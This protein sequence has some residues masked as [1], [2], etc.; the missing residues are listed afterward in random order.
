MT[1]T[2]G[3]AVKAWP[4]LLSIA[5]L[6]LSQ[7]ACRFDSSALTRKPD[8]A[9]HP[10][11]GAAAVTAS[12]TGVGDAVQDASLD[13]GSST[14]VP[15]AIGTT[16]PDPDADADTSLP[17]DPAPPPM[18]GGLQCEGV[19]C[20][21]A[22]DP[23]K[24]CCTRPVDV[25]ARTARAAG[26]C[27]LDL[28]A[29]QSS[30]YQD[31]CWQ[32]DQLGILDP[33]CPSTPG[34][35]DGGTS[36]PGC[37]G[38]DG[39]CGSVN[40]SQKLSCRHPLGSAKRACGEQPAG[41]VCDPTGNFAMRVS[42]DA[43]W[44]GRSGGLAALTDD[45]RGK[46]VV[47]LLVTIE[48]VDPMTQQLAV[49]GRVCGVTF[50]PFYS[51]T[52]CESYQPVFPD[53]I[54]EAAD[55]PKLPLTGRYAC[56]NGSCTV[57]VDPYTYLIGFEMQ[58][59]EAPWPPSTE[60]PMLT[61]PSGRGAACFPDHD[62]DGRAGVQ[63]LLPTNGKVKSNGASC[64]QGYQVRGAPLSASVAAIFN[65]VRR[66]DR[67][68]LGARMKIGASVRLD[69]DCKVARG[70]ALAEYVN[71]RAYGC[72]VEPG[73]AD[74]P[75]PVG[76]GKN[77]LCQTTEATFLDANLPLY[78]MLIAGAKPKP[79]LRLLDTSASQGPQASVVRLAASGASVSCSDVRNAAY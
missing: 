32:R 71:S 53:T 24:P 21:F 8:A 31:A 48:S 44:G 27:G 23:A 29:L 49:Q 59:R 69:P 20:P 60:T 35:P 2:K 37:C 78:D 17:H 66:T 43:A 75:N 79:A 64:T 67:L 55:V 61:C 28:S 65:G 34:D 73:T 12:D 51:T 42:A 47:Y 9:A 25:D 74:F 18:T 70:S 38:D 68:L 62:D 19:F 56:N 6:A 16:G 72:L 7:S 57:S 40:A 52:L 63:V 58:N 5:C 15:G 10:A 22:I 36:E 33:S 41:K 13:A 39:Q 11:A 26:R 45:G 50:P 3:V 4:V 76:A 14:V 1:E 46:I 77:E 30:S 54:W